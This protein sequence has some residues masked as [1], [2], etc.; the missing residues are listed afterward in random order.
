MNTA[1]NN[2]KILYERAKKAKTGETIVCP[3]C[4]GHFVKKHYQQAFCGKRG[5]ANAKGKRTL[6]KDQYDNRV[7]YH[8]GRISEHR[9]RHYAARGNSRHMTNDEYYAAM[10]HPMSSEALGQD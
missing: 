2:S 4:G 6:C 3:A 8:E 10:L 5:K 9:R 1:V 7:R